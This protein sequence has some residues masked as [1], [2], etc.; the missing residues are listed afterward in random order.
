MVTFSY[1]RSTSGVYAIQ[2]FGEMDGFAIVTQDSI[3]LNGQGWETEWEEVDPSEI[4]E[5]VRGRLMHALEDY[6]LE[7]TKFM[8][9]VERSG[10]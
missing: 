4:P 10:I 8:E 2:V 6:L 5:D 3:H 7:Y 1:I 9:S